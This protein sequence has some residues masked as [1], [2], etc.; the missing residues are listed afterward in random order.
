MHPIPKVYRGGPG[1][2]HPGRVLAA[3]RDAWIAAVAQQTP[4]DL[5]RDWPWTLSYL[6]RVKVAHFGLEATGH[7]RPAPPNNFG[8]HS[9]DRPACCAPWHLR[10]GTQAENCADTRDR[11]HSTAGE[12]NRWAVLTSAHVLVIRT[13]TEPNGVLSQRFGVDKSTISRIKTGRTWGHLARN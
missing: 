9:C 5:C 10:W 4:D 12:R 2:T 11:G 1:P 13:S 8:L 7:R 3:Q 6:R